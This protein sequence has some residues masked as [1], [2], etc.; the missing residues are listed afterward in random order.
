[1]GHV[2]IVLKKIQVSTPTFGWMDRTGRSLD[3]AWK[4]QW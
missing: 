3:A 4:G 2:S 1:M